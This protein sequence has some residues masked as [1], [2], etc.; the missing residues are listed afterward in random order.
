MVEIILSIRPEWLKKIFAGLKIIELRKSAPKCRCPFRVYFY[1][2]KQGRGSVVGE[3]VCYCAERAEPIEFS[4]LTAGSYLSVEEIIQY[5][6]KRSVYAWYVANPE[7]YDTLRP[8]SDLGLSRAPQ[9]WCY[10]KHKL[11]SGEVTA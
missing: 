2:T 9:S 3:C 11:H 6:G 5:A 4:S 10:A 8:L 7:Q 1:E